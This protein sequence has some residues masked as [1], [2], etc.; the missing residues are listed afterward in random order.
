[1]SMPHLLTLKPKATSTNK[2]L[3]R[4]L[5]DQS[6]RPNSLR[7]SIR[8]ELTR[9]DLEIDMGIV[10]VVEVVSFGSGTD[11]TTWASPILI[12]TELL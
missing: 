12:Y 1:M 5:P 6:R 7:H 11:S 10:G 4:T 3:G 2:V 8:R 9:E